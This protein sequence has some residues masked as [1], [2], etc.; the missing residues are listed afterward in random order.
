MLYNEKGCKP[1]HRIHY[2]G[3]ASA[4]FQ[5]LSQ[6]EDVGI[7]HQNVFL[8]YRFR[9]APSQQPT[10]LLPP[11]PLTKALRLLQ[12]TRKKLAAA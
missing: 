1:I 3:Y 10:A 9:H 4:E 2:M 8:H 12:R 6:G 7:P 11:S 5:R